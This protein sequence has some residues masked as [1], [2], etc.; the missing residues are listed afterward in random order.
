MV[1]AITQLAGF[2]LL[3]VK[4]LHARRMLRSGTWNVIDGG[5]LDG[6][7]EYDYTLVSVIELLLRD[8]A[9]TWW[10]FGLIAAGIAAGAASSI[11]QFVAS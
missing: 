1:A 9:G 11:V 7:S 8:A 10:A 5:R 3:I 2:A 6:R 4:G